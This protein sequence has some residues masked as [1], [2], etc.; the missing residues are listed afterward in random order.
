MNKLLSLNNFFILEDG[1]VLLNVQGAEDKLGQ[2]LDQGIRR[3]RIINKNNKDNSALHIGLLFLGFL[4][5][6]FE[7]VSRHSLFVS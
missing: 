2:F 4:R 1:P 6:E 3:R 5:L 7:N